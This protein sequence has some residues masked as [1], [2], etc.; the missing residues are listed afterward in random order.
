[1]ERK[2][3]VSLVSVR[4]AITAEVIVYRG[5]RQLPGASLIGLIPCLLAR[6]T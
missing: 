1:M 4:T 6:T 5:G 2:V 3:A